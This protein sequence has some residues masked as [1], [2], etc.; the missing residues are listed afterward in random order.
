MGRKIKDGVIEPLDVKLQFKVIV[1]N[2][3]L[4][5]QLPQL[6]MLWGYTCGLDD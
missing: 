4:A 6:M 3:Q 2:N 5:S 1:E